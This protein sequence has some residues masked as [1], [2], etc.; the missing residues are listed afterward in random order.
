MND[1]MNIELRN[2]NRKMP[3]RTWEETLMAMETE[4]GSNLCVIDNWKSRFLMQKALAL[5]HSDQVHRKEPKRYGKLKALVTDILHDQQQETLTAQKDSFV[6][7]KAIPVVPVKGKRC[8][9]QTVDLQRFMPK[10]Y[11]MFI[12]ALMTRIEER[13]KVTSD[14]EHPVRNLNDSLVCDSWH[15]SLSTLHK[16]SQC[17]AGNACS[18]VHLREHDRSPSSKKSKRGQ[19][20]RHKRDRQ[21]DEQR[22]TL[23]AT[24]KSVK[25]GKIK[26]CQNLRE[27][28]LSAHPTRHVVQKGKRMTE[29]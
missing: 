27:L 9:L 20:Q 12:L 10:R 17:R 22:K 7:D 16:K 3:D 29:T 8:G 21:R 5:N 25:E 19:C 1:L 13:Q 6:E 11:V 2:D 14:S 23:L 24:T 18:F 4:P 28:K 26:D 15:R